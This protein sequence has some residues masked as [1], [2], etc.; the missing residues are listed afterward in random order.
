MGDTYTQV[1]GVQLHLLLQLGEQLIV[2][3]LQLDRERTDSSTQPTCRPGCTRRVSGRRQG[4]APGTGGPALPWGIGAHL[5]RE[6]TTLQDRP[7][8]WEWALNRS[9]NGKLS[10]PSTGQPAF[11]PSPEAHSGGGVGV[12]LTISSS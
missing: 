9:P 8:L 10:W 4:P 7:G 5:M 1:P 6:L 2:K 11:G 12:G 3:G